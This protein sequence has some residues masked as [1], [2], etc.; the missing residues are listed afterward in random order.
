MDYQEGQ[1]FACIQ[2][3]LEKTALFSPGQPTRLLHAV[4][5]SL[6]VFDAIKPLL[7][8]L[9]TKPL[10]EAIQRMAHRL[11]QRQMQ[12][13][14][15]QARQALST[16]RPG[17]I[18]GSVMLQVHGQPQI[19]SAKALEELT[20][21]FPIKTT[22]ATNLAPR[23]PTLRQKTGALQCSTNSENAQRGNSSVFSKLA[24][25]QPRNP[26][27]RNNPHHP[28]LDNLHR[29]SQEDEAIRSKVSEAKA[30]SSKTAKAHK[31]SRRMEFRGLQ[32]SV[33][34]DKDEL[35]HWYDP[36]ND[37]KGTTKMK[38]PYG[39][40]RRTEGVDGDH[41]DVY[42]G[43]NEN[44]K[45]VYVVHQMK[46]PDFKK[47]DEDKVML[48]LDSAEAAKKAYLA[49]FNDE[50]FFGSMTT[51]PFEEFKTKVLATFEEPKKIAKKLAADMAIGQAMKQVRRLLKAKQVDQA[52]ELAQQTLR[53]GAVQPPMLQ[54][55]MTPSAGVTPH[56]A[57]LWEIASRSA[58][59]PRTQA[60]PIA[61]T[62]SAAPTLV[63]PDMARSW[64]K[65]KQQMG[66]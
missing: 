52:H 53:S 46:A 56:E 33:E 45:N 18:P 1:R 60:A 40:I 62:P 35:R 17:P 9:P 28:L 43:P 8:R 29:R 20:G 3:Q 16:A 34:T 51:M 66:W 32:I 19:V 64:A 57:R 21:A 42:V 15:T 14:V 22:P 36:H 23:V 47:Y 10:N 38:Y 12:R 58:K 41:V 65:T 6:N 39:Y 2:L 37:T 55:F 25:L 61:A 59:L 13:T 30:S 63:D 4:L 26:N 54:R 24:R 48:G 50:R 31:L 49:H 5:P 7:Q 44:A 27:L 11:E